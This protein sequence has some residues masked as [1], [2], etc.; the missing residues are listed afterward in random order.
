LKNIFEVE[1]IDDMSGMAQQ[2]I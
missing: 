1:L 2:I